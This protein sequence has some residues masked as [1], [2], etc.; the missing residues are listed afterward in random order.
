MAEAFDPYYIWLG[1]PPEEQPA[2]H[3]RLLGVRHFEGNEE[4]IVNAADQRVRHL[5]SMQTGKR[6]AETQKL[7]NEISAASGILLNAEKRQE[8]DSQLKAKEAAKQPASKPVAKPAA[9]RALPVAAPLTAAPAVSMP[10]SSS[11][12]QTDLFVAAKS[13]PQPPPKFPLIPLVVGSTLV[14]LVLGVVGVVGGWMLF[15]KRPQPEVPVV[16]QPKKNDPV[17]TFPKTHVSRRE[18]SKGNE[19][20]NS[21]VVPATV[22]K[23]EPNVVPASAINTLSTSSPS[24]IAAPRWIEGYTNEGQQP[25]SLLREG[26]K[27]YVSGAEM[28]PLSAPTLVLEHDPA[29]SDGRHGVGFDVSPEPAYMLAVL[30]DQSQEGG[31]A[32][33]VPFMGR[34]ARLVIDQVQESSG[35]KSYLSGFDL[36]GQNKLHERSGSTVTRGKLLA[37]RGPQAVTIFVGENRIC[38][39][40]SAGIQPKF[41]CNYEGDPNQIGLSTAYSGF[42]PNRIGISTRGKVAL[43]DV[44]LIKQVKK[45][46]VAVSPTP[47]SVETVRLG[48]PV[49][50]LKDIQATHRDST[51]LKNGQLLTKVRQGWLANMVFDYVPSGEYLLEATV[52]RTSGKDGILFAINVDDRPC[53]V[54]LDCFV[55]EGR[56][57][58]SGL[59][60]INGQRLIAPTFPIAALHKG[61][62]LTNDKPSQVRVFVRKGNVSLEVDGKQLIDWKGD[63][64]SLSRMPVTLSDAGPRLAVG[65]WKSTYTIENLKVYP[66]V[67]TGAAVASASG[68]DA[69]EPSGKTVE[70]ADKAGTTWSFK[71]LQKTDLLADVKRVNLSGSMT[72]RNGIEGIFSAGREPDRAEFDFAIPAECIINT[73][74]TRLAGNDALTLGFSVGGSP[75]GLVVDGFSQEGTLSGLELIQG[76]RLNAPDHPA[77]IKGPLLTTGKRAKLRIFLKR[78]M[79]IAELDGRKIADWTPADGALDR[80][81]NHRSPNLR[82]LYLGMWL[83]TYHVEALTVTRA[84]VV[85][86]S[87]VEKKENIVKFSIPDET[88]LAKARADLKATFGDFEQKG[89]KPEEKLKLSQEFVSVAASEKVP[90]VRYALLDAA[91]RLAVEG[92]DVRAAVAVADALKESFEG[93]GLDIQLQTLKLA[94]TATLPTS[95]WETAAE[96][97]GE[98]A[99]EAQDKARL[100]LADSA[101]LLAVDFASH[102]KSVDFKKAVKQLR[103]QISAQLKEWA[104]VKAGEQ[105]LASKPD[106]PAANLAVGKWNCLHLGDWDKGIPQLAK[107]GDAKLAAAAVAER[108][109]K[110]LAAS[111]AWSAAAESLSG[112]EK[113]AALRHSLE[114]YQEASESLKGLEQLKAAKRVTEVSEVLAQ[115][116]NQSPAV[117]GMV[118][119]SKL[120]SDALRPGLLIRVYAGPPPKSPTPAL[121]VIGSFN[122]FLVQRSQLARE[123]SYP[124][125]R[126]TF[127]GIGYIDLDK[128]ESLQFH[129][130]N[131]IVLVDGN[132]VISNNPD[133]PV[134]TGPKKKNKNPDLVRRTI[135]KGRHSLQIVP[136]DATANGPDVRITRDNGTSVISYSPADLDSELNR[137]VLFHGTSAKGRF[138]FGNR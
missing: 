57:A 44:M 112:A 24:S 136:F 33:D 85:E 107:S 138:S 70:V 51:E 101:S 23:V 22:P 71:P 137:E 111:D 3:Y 115:A 54:D 108:D 4:V 97:A 95:A 11:A 77:V 20:G 100:E 120:A 43:R 60:L 17:V 35:E 41:F 50:I 6:Q 45:G 105:A 114:V 134:T 102:S 99:T 122:D 31:V 7:L 106:D 98:L 62:V 14:V 84:E 27:R 39:H 53:S 19:Q 89:K 61:A 56:G 109:D 52:T 72:E 29:K 110:L 13:P 83:S 59:E 55:E 133:S 38:A 15:G 129:A 113:L 48:K 49:D 32:I 26:V 116:E 1:I 78:D 47:G 94:A 123:L 36:I 69:N 81:P 42:G 92:Q 88:A 79:L 46:T 21:P 75:V 117:G 5:R 87:R 125:S 80:D 90:A 86:K 131:A 93:D 9:A 91:R 126:L 12:P 65:T 76:R 132:K 119:R 103:D 82:N 40:V 127:A 18:S 58:H 10:P 121:A 68:T 135:K 128:D 118:P 2:D 25:K 28:P 37:E 124:A 16:H 63:A 8:Y 30:L 66:I 67:T 64:A 96:L 34:T 130:R 74:F 73:T 104:V